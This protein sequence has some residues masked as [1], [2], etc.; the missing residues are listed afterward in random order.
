MTQP[1]TDAG[2]GPSVTV[3]TRMMVDAMPGRV[4]DSLMFYEGIEEPPPL[5]LQWLLP[6]P[7][8][9]QGSK[10]AVGDQATCL[11][12]GGH[13]LKRVTRIDAGKLY[14]FA[15]VEQK[16]GIGGTV[17]LSGGSYTLR[18]TAAGKTELGIITR[19]TSRNRPRWLIQPIEEAACHL[20]HR[21]LLNAIRI[22]AEAVAKPSP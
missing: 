7:I 8:R 4:W 20:F 17:R 11:Y 10:S 5:Y 14:E 18:E 1:A 22:K 13:L 12:Q 6:R 16:L 15:V 9:T 19:Y 2:F 21:H 3:E